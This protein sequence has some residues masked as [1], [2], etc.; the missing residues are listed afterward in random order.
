MQI[1]YGR[2]SCVQAGLCKL[3]LRELREQQLTTVILSALTV[4]GALAAGC[5]L[6]HCTFFYMLNPH[7]EV[8]LQQYRSVPQMTV[9][10]RL[11]AH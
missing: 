2:C 8:R 11:L 10:A 4:P 5:Y 3:R 9:A 6:A 7:A 1:V